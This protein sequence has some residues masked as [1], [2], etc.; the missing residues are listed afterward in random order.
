MDEL[1]R[2]MQKEDFTLV[3]N[4]DNP[5]I[6][7][8]GKQISG[9]VGGVNT[10]EYCICQPWNDDSGFSMHHVKAY[11]R[12]KLWLNQCTTGGYKYYLDLYLNRK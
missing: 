6:I 10:S 4:Y 11:D 12:L 2:A 7:L 1:E 5:S 3:D 9:S 8:F